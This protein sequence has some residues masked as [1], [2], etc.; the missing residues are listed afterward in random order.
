[1]AH[2]STQ[3]NPQTSQVVQGY[4]ITAYR[5]LTT[6]MIED[7]KAD[8]ARW[9]NERRAQT[10]RNTTGVQYRYSETHQSRQH[11]GPTEASYQ[12]DPYARDSG[13]DGGPRYPGTGAPG[14][15][16]A[17]GAAYQQQAYASTSGGGV[18]GS[19]PQP[20]Q[21]PPPTDP[22]YGA[23]PQGGS[24]LNQGYQSPQDHPYTAMGTNRNPRG[25]AANDPYA[26]PAASAA[27]TQQATYATSGP[28]QPGYPATTSPFQYSSQVPPPTAQSYATM[29]PQDPFYG[30]GAYNAGMPPTLRTGSDSLATPAGQST[31]QQPPQQPGF[32]A[33]GQQQGFAA[34]GQQYDET[35]R[36]RTS[37][38]PTNTQTNP[39]GPL[40]DKRPWNPR[41]IP[42][43]FELDEATHRP[44]ECVM[45]SA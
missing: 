21:S 39:S 20:Q 36:A 14:Y 26:N 38:T 32:T 22:R 7:L 3:Q 18:Y 34:Q 45:I 31:Q 10:S 33:Q 35:P 40:V 42:S 30:R 27:A 6:A 44:R 24:V 28:S 41:P 43:P 5:N 8:S 4:Y 37:A 23:P 16:G 19:Y 12:Q 11:H 15:T 29:Q 1:M 17:A 25:Y 13:F 2:S 9:D